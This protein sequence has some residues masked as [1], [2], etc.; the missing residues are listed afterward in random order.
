MSKKTPFTGVKHFFKSTLL[1]YKESAKENST[2]YIRNAARYKSIFSPFR[3]LIISASTVAGLYFTFLSLNVKSQSSLLNNVIKYSINCVVY[4]L[5][6]IAGIMLLFITINGFNSLRK[7]A[8]WLKYEKDNI[9]EKVKRFAK[10]GSEQKAMHNLINAGK[11]IDLITHF[12]TFYE[13]LDPKPTHLW[14]CFAVTEIVASI[15]LLSLSA[16]IY[17]IV[18]FSFK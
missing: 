1:I 7:Y 14:N 9:E 13:Q 15:S 16:V 12:P 6:Y 8:D 17:A 2:P 3:S 10:N 18:T 11:T 5:L 4:P